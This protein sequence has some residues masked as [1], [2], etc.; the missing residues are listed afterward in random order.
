MENSEVIG[1]RIFRSVC[2]PKFRS[3][4]IAFLFNIFHLRF[5]FVVA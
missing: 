2:E 5:A 4:I 3:A 1:V